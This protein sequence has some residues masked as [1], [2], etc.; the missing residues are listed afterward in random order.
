MVQIF[1]VTCLSIEHA[2]SNIKILQ[3]NNS[4]LTAEVYSPTGSFRGPWQE[5]NGKETNRQPDQSRARDIEQNKNE[6]QMENTGYLCRLHVL[7]VLAKS[8]LPCE[9]AQDG[10]SNCACLIL[11]NELP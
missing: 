9:G 2:S 5:L 6:N 8:H 1:V 7:N 10:L 3:T 11:V 4:E